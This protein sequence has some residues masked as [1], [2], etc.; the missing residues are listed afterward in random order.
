MRLNEARRT[1][2]R[3]RVSTVRTQGQRAGYEGSRVFL[4]R[5]QAPGGGLKIII[6]SRGRRPSCAC[7]RAPGRDKGQRAPLGAPAEQ[8]TA[9]KPVRRCGSGSPVNSIALRRVGLDRRAGQWCWLLVLQAGTQASV[10]GR[11]LPRCAQKPTVRCSKNTG[12]SQRLC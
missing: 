12:H 10:A 5:V 4:L 1:T 2:W 7:A 3:G 9:Q 8:M 6:I 11:Q